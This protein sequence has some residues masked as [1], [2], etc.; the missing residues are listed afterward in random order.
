MI[1]TPNHTLGRSTLLLLV[2][3]CALLYAVPSRAQFL[4]QGGVTGIVK[5]PGG[6]VIRGADVVLT[7]V[8]TSL[9]LTTKTDQSGV[10]A[11]SPVKIG[12]YSVTVIAS[13]FQKTTQQNITVDL[14]QRTNVSIALQPGGVNQSIT[15]T[16]APR[17]CATSYQ[18]NR[19]RLSI[20]SK[21]C[22]RIWGIDAIL[23]SQPRLHGSWER[24]GDLLPS[25]QLQPAAE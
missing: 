9:K 17:I 8:E 22:L 13:G 6:A 12:Q 21:A 10:Y 20:C 7:N 19:R 11:F 5:D 3:L 4:D 23:L 24:L 1:S 16:G 14:G 2:L 18:N 15:V 25:H